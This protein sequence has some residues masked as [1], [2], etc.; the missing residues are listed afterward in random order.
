[1][2]DIR[3][4]KVGDIVICG[5]IIPYRQFFYIHNIDIERNV[6]IT[7]GINE[8]NRMS[9]FKKSG[10]WS[11]HRKANKEESDMFF[12]LIERYGFKF[13]INIGVTRK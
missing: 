6:V 9:V 5:E 2:Y 8:G 11:F 13:N 7:S 4:L 12:D 3:D 10:I 1:M